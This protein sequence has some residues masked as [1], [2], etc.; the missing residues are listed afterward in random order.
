MIK[1]LG[2][3]ARF[4]ARICYYRSFC[5]ERAERIN[6]PFHLAAPIPMDE[7]ELE[8]KLNPLEEDYETREL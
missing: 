2:D 1:G 7:D 4:K 8:T 6:G 3:L 5:F